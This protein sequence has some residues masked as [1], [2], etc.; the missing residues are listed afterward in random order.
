M[1]SPMRYPGGKSKTKVQKLILAYK[2]AKISEYREPFVGGGGIFF[3]LQPAP[4]LKRWINDANED[5]IKVYLAFRDHADEFIE[6]CRFIKP[7]QPGEP[8]VSTK[9]ANGAKYNQR[10]G[11]EFKRFAADTKGWPALRYFFIN[12]TVWGGRVNY[13]PA[14][15]S[16][17][18]YSNPKGWNVVAKPHF[19]EDVAEHLQGTRITSGSY[20][21]LL[22]EDGQDVWVYLDPPY[23]VDTEFNGTDKLYQF[24]FTK[25]D[26]IKFA[27]T[28][29]KSKHKLCISY[30]NQ[31]FIKDLFKGFHIHEHE[32]VYSGAR[33]AG[34]TELKRKTGK[35]LIITN[36]EKPGKQMSLDQEYETVSS[37]FKPDPLE[38][39]CAGL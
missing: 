5:L 7:M 24:G 36:Y 9:T 28:C 21:Q 2:P 37:L 12:R 8:E 31:D 22:L 16:R 32:W 27:E 30:D 20:E 18:Y 3:G 35:E 10:L 11:E 33:K 39:M 26:H 19:L 6:A 25:E 29:R 14:M 38:D 13:D 1:H 15:A 23:L 17:M 4:N 34:E